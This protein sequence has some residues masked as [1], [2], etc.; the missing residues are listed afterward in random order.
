[1]SRQLGVQPQPLPATVRSAPLHRLARGTLHTRQGHGRGRF[2]GDAAHKLTHGGE[3]RAALRWLKERSV[4]DGVKPGET[5][6]LARS[7]TPYRDLIA[8]VAAE[9][10]LPVHFAGA[11][12]LRQNPAIAA[13]LDLLA[14]FLPDAA[15]EGLRLPRRATVEA[16]R[17]PYFN[18]QEG[19]GGPGLLAG[20]ADRL[21][22]V[23]RRYRVIRGLA[24][25]REAFALHAVQRT[26]ERRRR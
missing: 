21:D 15:G 9:F 5:A 16:W 7:L 11:L 10:G 13:L 18:W 2:G 12:P 8:Q 22:A 19:E 3:V 23:A 1:M 14:L 4:V 20:D 17:S 26:D 6:L 25:W 24:Q